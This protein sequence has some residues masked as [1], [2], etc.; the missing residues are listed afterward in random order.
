[1]LLPK[2]VSRPGCYDQN[3][4]GECRVLKFITKKQSYANTTA[5]ST[6]AAFMENSMHE[7]NK[8][9]QIP[10]ISMGNLPAGRYHGVLPDKKTYTTKPAH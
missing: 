1:L 4:R 6:H 9:F 3:E 5:F 10:C 7:K 8:P 2:P